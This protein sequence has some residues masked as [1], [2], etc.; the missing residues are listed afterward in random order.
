MQPYLSA[1]HRWIPFRPSGTKPTSLSTFR[2]CR[3]IEVSLILLLLLL[4]LGLSTLPSAFSDEVAFTLPNC[5][6]YRYPVTLETH[7]PDTLTEPVGGIYCEASRLFASGSYVLTDALERALGP[8]TI[9]NVDLAAYY[10]VD[11]SFA[12]WLCSLSWAKAGRM[13]IYHQKWESGVP[14]VSSAFHSRLRACDTPAQFIPLGCDIFDD[15]MTTNSTSSTSSTLCKFGSVNLL[16]AKLGRFL[17]TSGERIIFTGSGNIN[18]SLYAN[19]DDWVILKRVK[20]VPL[21]N[22]VDCIFSTLNEFIGKTNVKVKEF[23]SIQQSCLEAANLTNVS[24]VPHLILTPLDGAQYFSNVISA[25]KEADNVWIAS[26]FLG[27]DKRIIDALSQKDQGNVK[28]L[29]D[30]DNYWSLYTKRDY[31]YAKY[32]RT[33]R[34][35]SLQGRADLEIRYLQTNHHSTGKDRNMLHTRIIMTSKGADRR[36][37]TGSA[38]WRQNSFVF[39]VEQQMIIERPELV[40]QYFTFFNDLWQRGLSAAS[41]PLL[42]VKATFDLP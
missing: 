13:R 19:I 29:L 41:M 12:D 6:G 35:S 21:T 30:D 1:L 26:Q 27:G 32:Q 9:L 8:S 37:Y 31:G 33:K 7:G 42:D 25:I 36:V 3:F 17:T 4:G 16:H 14:H 5:P 40:E 39:N 20:P 24:T 22:R 11:E 10:F 28:I 18:K 38:H 2:V 15:R 23:R 34:L